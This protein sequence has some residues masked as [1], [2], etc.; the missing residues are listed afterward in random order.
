MTEES[1]PQNSL[2]FGRY[3]PIKVLGEGAMG[4]VYL[5]EDPF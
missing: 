4:R 2:K 3:Q 1:N 5:A